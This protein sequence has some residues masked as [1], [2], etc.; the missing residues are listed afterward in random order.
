MFFW[1]VDIGSVCLIDK[2]NCVWF[3]VGKE[4]G[5]VFVSCCSVDGERVIVIG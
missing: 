1:F 3:Y 5:W 4:M 2:I